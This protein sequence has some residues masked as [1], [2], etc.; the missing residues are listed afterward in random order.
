[1]DIFHTMF[2][3]YIHRFTFTYPVLMIQFSTT[4]FIVCKSCVTCINNDN[5]NKN[6]F[7]PIWKYKF[8]L[9]QLI[10][11]YDWQE[12][13]LSL[14]NILISYT[15]YTYPYYNNRQ[16]ET[17]KTWKYR[18]LWWEWKVW[19][20]SIHFTPK[21]IIFWCFECLILSII[22]I[23]TMH[24]NMDILYYDYVFEIHFLYRLTNK[25][26]SRS[27]A[28]ITNGNV[29]LLFFRKVKWTKFLHVC[30]VQVLFKCVN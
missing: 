4:Y 30:F 25:N 20:R 21:N 8:L 12:S 28:P 29:F 3:Q 16:N 5:M 23:W 7:L 1:M 14:Y 26:N 2:G 9:L 24:C 19:K 6:L 13:I 27:D 22:V 17:R 10:E 18:I 15:Y 11:L